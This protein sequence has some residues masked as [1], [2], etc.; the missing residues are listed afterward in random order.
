M[1]NHQG[2]LIGDFTVGV[3]DDGLGSERFFVFGSGPAQRYHERWFRQQMREAGADRDGSVEL[4]VW[5]PELTGLSIAG[6][7]ARDVLAPLVD[8]EV[9]NE[10]F[11]FLDLRDAWVGSVPA[12]VGRISFTGDLGYEI[13]C[14]AGYQLAL[15]D[16]LMAAGERYGLRLFGSR[17]LDS[18]RLDKGWGAWATEYR[19]IY[20]PFEAGLGWT[21]RL[22]KEF[23]GRDAAT[24]AKT[25]GPDRRLVLFSMD[26]G[27]GP[28]AADCTGNEPIWY[29]AGDDARVVGWV[30]SG[31]YA[32]HSGLSL[33]L[34][35]I[36]TEL[37]S[38][39]GDTVGA[40]GPWE[41]E[42]VGS[43]RTA[44]RL[45]EPPFDPAGARMRG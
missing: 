13:W 38:E 42:V 18:M 24:A 11:G 26:A 25:A 14:T 3:V 1:L 4:R 12:I 10:S 40:D 21:V 30:T 15:F 39:P 6:P 34:G 7:L 23:I 41:I 33:A 29:G 20:D 17:A 9:S 32:H 31:G 27:T 2:R 37:L 22:D 8:F 44:I 35:Y 5:G 16:A 36:P 45:T 19:P 28:D 43:R